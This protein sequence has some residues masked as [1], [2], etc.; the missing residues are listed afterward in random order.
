MSPLSTPYVTPAMITNAPTGIA[1]AI[2]PFP[3]STSQQQY[4]EQLNICRRATSIVNGY[5]NQVLR[6]TV[7]TE[8]QNGPDYRVTI[9]NGTGNARV[10]LQRWPVTS[11]LQV[12]VSANAFPRQ[13]T[14]VPGNWYDIENPILG[15]YGSTAPSSAGEGG[16]SILIG[17][18]YINWGLGRRGY[19]ASVTYENGWPHAGTTASSLAGASTLAVDDVTSFTGASAE[20]F[21]G[22]SSE[23]VHVTSVTAN[24]PQ[25]LP[26]G[27]TVP[28]GPGT[29]TLAS[30]LT[31][32]H[33]SGIV[34]SSF[35]QDILWATILAATTQALESGINSIT[36]QNVN[37]SQTVGGHGI[38][39]LITD[40]EVILEPF[41]RVI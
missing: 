35:P 12:A 2:I 3:K 22:A 4:A 16:Q 1:W 31:Y 25:P 34:V 38:E 11:I 32:A 33:T 21:D 9:E 6:A 24:T 8:V 26:Y 5:C 36:I 18:G 41:R 14:T 40:Y 15:V 29:L 27:G 28:A 17:P 37:G 10:I 19:V 13:Y 20:V 39:E 7:D 23:T 30:P